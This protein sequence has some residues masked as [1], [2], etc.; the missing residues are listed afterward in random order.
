MDYKTELD[1]VLNFFGRY[2]LDGVWEWLYGKNSTDIDSAI[3]SVLKLVPHFIN[4]LE[5]T[6]F[7]KAEESSKKVNLLLEFCSSLASSPYFFSQKTISFLKTVIEK[8]QKYELN[9]CSIASSGNKTYKAHSKATIERKLEKL[10]KELEKEISK[11]D[12]GENV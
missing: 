10:I 9:K 12:K 11:I 2:G 7:S 3:F 6:T 1:E 4:S 5:Y 8:I